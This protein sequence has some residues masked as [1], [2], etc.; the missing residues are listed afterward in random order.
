MLPFDVDCLLC[1]HVTPVTC[2]RHCCQ[3]LT[4][5]PGLAGSDEVENAQVAAAVDTVG[6]LQKELLKYAFEEDK[7][8]QVSTSVHV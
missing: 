3:P 1:W 4:C 6:D 7:D 5:A 2:H 8:K